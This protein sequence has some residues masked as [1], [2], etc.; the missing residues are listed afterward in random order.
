MISFPDV[1]GKEKGVTLHFCAFV[2]SIWRRSHLQLLALIASFPSGRIQIFIWFTMTSNQ[3]WWDCGDIYGNI[4][5]QFCNSTGE[6]AIF[7]L[8]L[9]K[10][11]PW[12][13]PWNF[14]ISLAVQ[15]IPPES[16]S[17]PNQIRPL[18]DRWV[19]LVTVYNISGLPAHSCDS[20]KM[21]MNQQEPKLGPRSA[22]FFFF[23]A[24]ATLK[25]ISEVVQCIRKY[26]G[27]SDGGFAAGGHCDLA[28]M[29]SDALRAHLSCG[30]T[31]E[32]WGGGWSTWHLP[33]SFREQSKTV[34]Q[35]QSSG[36]RFW[37]M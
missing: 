27:K 37:E 20:W 2:H 10:F 1:K 9:S 3:V 14:N 33:L 31:W 35:L 24:G 15:H 7:H 30:L 4:R 25:F 5:S 13:P 26:K 32:T 8:L 18:D 21:P 12:T 16:S 22:F 11:P 29:C 6:F 34:A 36:T 17:A 28:S 19:G 23:S